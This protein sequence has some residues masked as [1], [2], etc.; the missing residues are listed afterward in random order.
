MGLV[1]SHYQLGPGRGNEG[2]GGEGS[3][4]TE[5]HWGWGTG[6]WRSGVCVGITEINCHCY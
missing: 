6:S 1:W 3:E 5:G 2:R 4:E